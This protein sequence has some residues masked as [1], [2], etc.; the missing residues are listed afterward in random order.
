MKKKIWIFTPFVQTEKNYQQKFQSKRET[1]QI[2]TGLSPHFDP[3]F[4]HSFVTFLSNVKVLKINYEI[5]DTNF[6]EFLLET[7]SVFFLFLLI[8]SRIFYFILIHSFSSRSYQSESDEMT[9]FS[10]KWKKRIFWN[11]ILF[12]GNF[13][14]CLKLCY[15]K[16]SKIDSTDNMFYI[17]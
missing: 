5:I 7:S 15:I 10:K 16:Q 13:F 17:T 8:I 11:F 4:C 12:I 9:T 2:K 14:L 3:L 1:I 6:T